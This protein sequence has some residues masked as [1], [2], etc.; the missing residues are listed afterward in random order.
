M[1]QT[2]LFLFL[3]LVGLAGAYL[4]TSSFSHIHIEEEKEENFISIEQKTQPEEIEEITYVV[5]TYADYFTDL[6]ITSETIT[7]NDLMGVGSSNNPYIVKSTKGFMYLSNKTISKINLSNKY[8]ELDCDIIL[9]DELFDKNGNPSGGDGKIYSF[10][11][12]S[13]WNIRFDGNGHTISGFYFNDNTRSNI[14]LVNNNTGNFTYFNNV[15]F[16]NLFIIGNK[17]IFAVGE[18][19]DA[20]NVVL[21]SGTIKGNG[22]LAGLFYNS[23]KGKII[24]CINHADIYRENS[25]TSQINSF[26]GVCLF[27]TD[28]L[29]KDCKNYGN[30]IVNKGYYLGG[31]TTSSKNAIIDHCENYGEIIGTQAVGGIAGQSGGNNV[32]RN[33]TNY[34]KTNATTYH[35][36]GI[37]AEGRTDQIQSCK[38]FGEVLLGGT[39]SYP[40]GGGICSVFYGG[41]LTLSDCHN[42]GL[43][44]AVSGTTPTMGE[45]VAYLQISESKSGSSLNIL[46]CISSSR[47]GANAFG[48]IHHNTLP[49]TTINIKNCS[50][51]YIET[52]KNP[53]YFVFDTV[54]NN[55]TLNIN[56]LKIEHKDETLKNYFFGT[57]ENGGVINI[58]NLLVKSRTQVYSA[59]NFFRYDDF[60]KTAKIN[61]KSIIG[62]FETSVSGKSFYYG[63]IFSG[64][65]F[66]WKT[67]ELGLAALGGK[68]MFQGQVDEEYLNRKGFLKKDI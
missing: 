19:T 30:I 61:V 39:Y 57:I 65:Y 48:K 9:N 27:A 35:N 12:M 20:E 28:I 1:K 56:G 51:K 26:A 6:N 5:K 67:G 15:I 29:I 64:Y 60:S 58:S 47:S 23:K 46:N 66:S 50:I 49:I 13:G 25:G 34:G 8:I 53:T 42:Y 21:K 10:E 44:H 7:E 52:E 32:I 31:I 41:V 4:G 3:I 43:I 22:G 54:P 62:D 17:Y 59:F 36:A 18:I 33:C 16:E 63:E 38:N 55:L 40:T 24:N 14:C 11:P 2:L 37:I 68:G 45:I